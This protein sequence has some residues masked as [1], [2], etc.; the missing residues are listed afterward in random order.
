VLS[1]PSIDRTLSLSDP[2]WSPD[3]RRLAVTGARDSLAGNITA[4]YVV[5]VRSGRIRQLTD[6]PADTSADWSRRGEI[7]FQ[8]A[9]LAHDPDD[10]D[11]FAV[12][13]D[14]SG[15][16]QITSGGGSEPDWS[17]DGRRLAF[18][19]AVGTGDD[20]FTVTAAGLALRR[21]THSGWATS[22]AWSPGGR[23]I[24][25]EDGGAIRVVPARGGKSQTIAR[26]GREHSFAA[27]AWRPPMVPAER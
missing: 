6:G 22:P 7:A 10:I 5:D 11:V 27:P 13:P 19:R 3:G 15:I 16:R 8:R 17:P 23:L 20:V 21:V 9:G 18:V 24:A 1:P 2:T 25:F 14:G 12:R 26:P 4:I